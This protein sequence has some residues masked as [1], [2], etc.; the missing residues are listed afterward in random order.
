MPERN[1]PCPCGS[2][3]KYKKCCLK[4][5]EAKRK[6]LP[7]DYKKHEPKFHQIPQEE[8]T[9]DMV[10][11]VLQRQREGMIKYGLLSKEKE[12]LFRRLLN[13]FI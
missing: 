9:E 7:H 11:R 8:V 3:L 10:K 6:I 1:Q 5:D 13:R 2:N 12:S 4:K